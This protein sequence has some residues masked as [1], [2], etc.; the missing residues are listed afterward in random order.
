M[1]IDRD[2]PYSQT[3]NEDSP[4]HTLDI[5]YDLARIGGRRKPVIVFIHGGSWF[6]KDKSFLEVSEEEAMWAWF[7][8]QGYV[9]AGLN[10]RLA[11]LAYPPKTTVFDM[12]DDIARGIKWLSV[13]GVRYGGKKNGFILVG[14]SSGAH[15]AV[16]IAT[17]ERYL[18]KYHLSLADI[19]GVIAM[20][21]AHYDL[22]QMMKILQS[23]DLGM[24]HQ[25]GMYVKMAKILGRTAQEQARIS[26]VAFLGE[27]SKNI[28]FL[29]LSARPQSQQ[30]SAKFCL[31]LED[32]GIHVLHYH[33]E[34]CSHSDFIFR[35]RGMVSKYILPF[36]GQIQQTTESTDL[37]QWNTIF[38]K[39]NSQDKVIAKSK[40]K[41]EEWLVTR[42]K[43]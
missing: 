25:R 13:N 5:Y 24:P 14:H 22:P 31:L 15:L 38:P 16:L 18:R 8:E 43:K 4:F 35:F 2:I 3:S 41:F 17:D 21:G 10:F 36:L 26:P 7:V 27:G 30:M 1:K 39:A 28:A 37:P 23:E 29:L 11:D 20:D 19:G 42:K 40:F 12:V 9:F 32:I 34:R 33:F 6:E